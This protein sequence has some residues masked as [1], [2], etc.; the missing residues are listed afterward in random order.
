MLTCHSI[1]E[2]DQA[3]NCECYVEEDK[4]PMV[5]QP[6]TTGQP[7]AM[8]VKS[9]ATRVAELAVLGAIWDHNL[10]GGREG[11]REGGERY[12]ELD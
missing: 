6:H 11:G 5:V 4:E 3:L 7:Q 10:W 12:M 1:P 8:V 2:E 9:I